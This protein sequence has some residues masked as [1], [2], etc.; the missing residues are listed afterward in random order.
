MTDK[1]YSEIEV[2]GYPVAG[3]FDRL[4]ALLAALDARLTRLEQEVAA[5]LAASRE[6]RRRAVKARTQ[7]AG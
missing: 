4:S 1:S 3:T 6:A 2:G 7:G 5:T